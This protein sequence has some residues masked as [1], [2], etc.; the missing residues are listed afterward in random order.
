MMEEE[1]KS[2]HTYTMTEDKMMH[3]IILGIVVSTPP[4]AVQEDQEETC[5]Q[6]KSVNRIISKKIQN[7]VLVKLGKT[8]ENKKIFTI[9]RVGLVEVLVKK[10]RQRKEA[11]Q[12]HRCQR[13]LHTQGICNNTPRCVKCGEPLRHAPSG[14]PSMRCT[15]SP[16]K[17]STEI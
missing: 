14:T 12:C 2:Y 5:F 1:K 17:R 4:E 16:T 11:T 15:T 8:E 10:Q 9:T 7:L 13:F 3:A 6:P